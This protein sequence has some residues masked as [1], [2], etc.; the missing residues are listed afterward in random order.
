MT[1]SL[2]FE[3]CLKDTSLVI[4]VKH[5]HTCAETRRPSRK[6]LLFFVLIHKSVVGTMPDQ[7]TDLLVRQQSPENGTLSAANGGNSQ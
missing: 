2:Y 1:S 4:Y 6:T 5:T 7:L 3:E